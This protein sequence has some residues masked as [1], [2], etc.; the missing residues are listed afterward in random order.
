MQR[1]APVDFA[2]GLAVLAMIAWHTADGLLKP[3]L[4]DTE[5]FLSLRTVG[6]LAAPGFL[7][8]AG[9]GAAL[10]A[11]PTSDPLAASRKLR[12]GLGRGCEILIL[13]YALR[14]QT[15]LIDAA[16]LVHIEMLR[17]WLPLLI[18]YAALFY[19][20][21]GLARDRP[22]SPRWALSGAAL[23]FVGWIQVEDVADGRL[24]RLLQVDVL[25][26]IGA[27]LAL[28]AVAEYAVSLLQ[29]P[30]WACALG[31]SCM[32]VA[33]PLRAQL[34]GTLPVPLAAYLGRF[35][36]PPDL[37]PP[38]LFPL[39]PWFAYACLG[40]ALGVL[41]RRAHERAERTLV[42]FGVVGASVALITSEAHAYVHAWTQ[43]P[44][45]VTPVRVMFRVGLVMVW[46]ALGVAFA[47]TALGRK[48]VDFGRASLRVYWFH[49]PFAYGIAVQWLRGQLTFAAWLAFA[50]LLA[51]AMWQLTR[52]RLPQ[53]RIPVRA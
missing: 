4:R 16:A 48:L 12:R 28:L 36:G 35:D 7:L 23:V 3:A 47:R 31:V 10:A 30:L 14:L 45:A 5:T 2:R 50:L 44:L 6:G 33:E 20:A 37:P 38:S 11:K 24:A 40:A 18:G 29:R 34:P 19:A 26:S 32:I 52:V 21:R 9:M 42:A 17:A 22:V 8:L 43:S 41:L 39:F 27:S 53:D 15:W 46:L 25:Q 1:L 51:A 49:L 13:G